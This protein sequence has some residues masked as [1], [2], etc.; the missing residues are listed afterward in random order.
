MNV[1]RCTLHILGQNPF[2][3]LKGK[4]SETCKGQNVIFFQNKEK[5]ISRN[6][7]LASFD[8]LDSFE[9][10]F[11]HETAELHFAWLFKNLVPQA[12]IFSGKQSII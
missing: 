6:F 9:L 7:F 2:R 3:I 11:G 1:L 12:Q 4:N 10:T 5:Y 8:S